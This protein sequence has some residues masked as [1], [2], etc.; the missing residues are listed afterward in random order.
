MFFRKMIDDRTHGYSGEKKEDY[1]ILT[2]GV[3]WLLGVVLG[4]FSLGLVVFGAVRE[5]VP[6]SDNTCRRSFASLSVR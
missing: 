6:E 5:G 2:F 4:L 1:A 3:R